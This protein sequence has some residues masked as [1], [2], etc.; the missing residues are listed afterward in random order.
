MLRIELVHVRAEY[1]LKINKMLQ[2]SNSSLN[3]LRR[4]NVDNMKSVRVNKHKV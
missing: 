1:V 2:N 3:K 4:L